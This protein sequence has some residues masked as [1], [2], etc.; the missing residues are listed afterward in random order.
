VLK[1]LRNEVHASV[2]VMI[3]CGD[4]HQLELLQQQS[5]FQILTK[6]SSADELIDQVNAMITASSADKAYQKNA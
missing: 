4:R 2:P 6:G 5:R 3:F 1:F